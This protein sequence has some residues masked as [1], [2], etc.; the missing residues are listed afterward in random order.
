MQNIAIF[1]SG[2][3]S[4]AQRIAEY[5]RDHPTIRILLIVSNKADAYVLER[6][7]KLG[8]PSCVYSNKEFRDANALITQLDEYK[9]DAIVLAGFLLKV[10]DSLIAAYPNRIIN[11][12]PAL[13]PKY[14][15]KGMY[16][17]FVHEAVIAALEKE[18]GITIHLVNERYDEGEILFQKHCPVLPDD[19]A[20]SLAARI[21]ELEHRYF[22]EVIEKWLGKG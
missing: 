8:I 2:N 10:A 7:R 21:H 11:I 1:A 16:G 9:I 4:N 5:F 12:H 6:A 19:D 20:D 15:G 17:H 22:P 3:G 18:S 14:G 13:L